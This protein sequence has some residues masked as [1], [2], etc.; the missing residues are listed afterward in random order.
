MIDR[1]NVQDCVL[2]GSC[3]NICPVNAI[4]FQKEYLDF[5]Y[6]EID[7]KKCIG[8]DLCERVCPVLKE[9]VS[10]SNRMNSPL[11]YIARNRSSEVRRRSTSGGI[12]F[13]AAQYVLSMGGYIC[14]A[15][16]DD[17]FHV[18][19]I[20]TNDVEQ[21]Q[22]MLGSK[23]AQSDMGD[24][25]RQ[26][27][28]IL[29]R[30]T[31]VLFTGCPCQIAGLNAYLRKNYDNLIL[32]ELICHGIPSDKMLQSYIQLL[33]SL[34]HAKLTQIQFRNKDKGWHCSAVSASFLNGSS[35][36][37][38]ITVD[39]YM[40]GFLGNIYLKESCYHCKFRSFKSG[41]DLMIGDFW[42]AETEMPQIDDNTGLSAVLIHSKKGNEF[43]HQLDI[44][45]YETNVERIIY[46]NRSIIESA[47][48]NKNRHIFYQCAEIN[49]YPNAI[50]KILWEKII[51]KWKRQV[52]Y[53][54]RCIYYKL[55]GRGKPLY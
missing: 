45:C 1:I 13:A 27:K 15:I 22:R 47:Q 55:S 42:G 44:D 7:K 10:F 28:D 20:C 39:A 48:P 9:I 17:D 29:L 53:V 51:D 3:M 4:S 36:R 8:C 54:L 2:C 34:Y 26:V 41:A 30:G 52:H 14:G 21:V 32:M 33:E 18:K 6:P 16:F 37:N 12:F 11:A 50:Y 31:L 5:C 43:F 49:G 24:I 23:Y 38:P 46:Y 19:H 35:Y 40:R 25:F